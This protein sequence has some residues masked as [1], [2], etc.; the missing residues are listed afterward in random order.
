LECK[1][2]AL[3]V[4]YNPVFSKTKNRQTAF[5]GFCNS[6]FLRPLSALSC[7]GVCLYCCLHSISYQTLSPFFPSINCVHS[8]DPRP[9]DDAAE[10]STAGYREKFADCRRC[11]DRATEGIFPSPS[12]TAN[13]S[14]R[15]AIGWFVR[16]A[17]WSACTYF[18]SEGGS[19]TAKG[20]N[21]KGK[22][23]CTDRSCC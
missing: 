19:K 4:E 1:L 9:G 21:K 6:A 7:V 3:Y 11:S 22:L 20:R 5:D 15:R 18:S 14:A 10:Q 13:Q 17:P 2:S 23:H 12:A 8:R 16:G